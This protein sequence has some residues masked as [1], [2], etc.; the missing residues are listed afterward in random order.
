MKAHADPSVRTRVLAASVS[1]ALIAL[2]LAAEAQAP[3]FKRSLELSVEV[4][5]FVHDG[6][7]PEQRG[8]S[9]SLSAEPEFD[10]A[11]TENTSLRFVP[12]ARWDQHDDERTHADIRE[13]A[14]RLRHGNLDA[15]IGI[16]RVFWGVIESVHL[17][18]IINQTDL[19]ENPDGEEKL[20]QPMLNLM[21]STHFGNVS[22]FVLPYFRERTLPGERGRLRAALPYDDRHAIYESNDEE[23]HVDAALRYTLSTG[24][25]DLGL[26]HFSGTTREP[27]LIVRNT[28]KGPVLTPVY[29]LIERTGIDLNFVAG[30]WLW[31]LEAAHQDDRFDAYSAAAAG[32]EYTY[33]GAFGS[34]WD[35]GVL[36]E[37][38]WDERGAEGGAAFQNDVFLGTRWSGNDVEGTELLAGA[39]FDL[40]HG[41]FFGT[42]EGSRRVGAAGK[43][44]LEVRLFDGGST[45]DPFEAFARDDYVQVEYTH[46]W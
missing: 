44:V 16:G 6:T 26:S 45:S 25:L 19:V 27:R 32:F 29:D 39:A 8:S 21:W 9:I 35:A 15:V 12:F 28:A 42:V 2:S 1:P 36:L 5:G 18:D 23:Q 4:R 3:K 40:D 30:A 41:G 46:Y 37:Y 20:G 24:A 7:D 10:Y 17:V 43:L 34:A 22:A 33:S 13:L 14:V 31:K 11:L 38:L